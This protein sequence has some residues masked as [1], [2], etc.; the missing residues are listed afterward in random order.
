MRKIAITMRVAESKIGARRDCL[1]QDYVQFYQQFGIGLI[2]FPN[3]LSDAIGHIEALGAEGI[4]LSGGNDIA[5][6]LYG[7]KK[8]EGAGYAPERDATERLLLDFAARKKMPVLCECRGAQ[9]MNVYFGGRLAKVDGHVVP[10]HGITFDGIGREYFGV[11]KMNVNSYHNFG[12]SESLLSPK[13]RAFAKADDGAVEGFFHPTLP[14]A[15]VMWHPE[16]KSPDEKVN[17]MLANAF[18]QRKWFWE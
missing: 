17:S 16:R 15:G 7:G 4:I 6:R 18:A 12:F 14:F 11:E 5:P 2:P 9:F 8:E 10:S 3:V 13:L 1:E